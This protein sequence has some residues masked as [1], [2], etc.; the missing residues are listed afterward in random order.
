VQENNLPAGFDLTAIECHDTATGQTFPGDLVNHLVD[1]TMTAGESVHCAFTNTQD[2]LLQ[3]QVR[4]M[5]V[6]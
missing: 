2:S 3:M 5:T 6:A 1:L 4:H